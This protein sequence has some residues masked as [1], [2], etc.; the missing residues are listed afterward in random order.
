MQDEIKKKS[1]KDAQ[2]SRLTKI[3]L[4]NLNKEVNKSFPRDL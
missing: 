2:C 3:F 1:F 4:P